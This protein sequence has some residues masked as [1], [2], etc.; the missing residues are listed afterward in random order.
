MG[1]FSRLGNDLYSGKKSINFVGRKWLWYC[2]SGVIV[3]LAVAGL[4]FKGLNMGIEFVGGA[5]Y[6]RDARPIGRS[7]RTTPTR[8]ARPSPAPASRAPAPRSSPRRV[9]TA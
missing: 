5:Q 3:L 2:V 6:T 8:Y 7:T 4:Y 9:R 1:K